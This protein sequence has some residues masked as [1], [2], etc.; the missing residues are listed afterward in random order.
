MGDLDDFDTDE[1]AGT[2]EITEE[3]VKNREKALKIKQ[4]L[5]E[6][7]EQRRFREEIGDD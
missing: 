1:V 7:M 4:R 2:E 6:I 3:P 5:D